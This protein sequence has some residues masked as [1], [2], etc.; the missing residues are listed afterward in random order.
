MIKAKFRDNLIGMLLLDKK[1]WMH[2]EI[3]VNISIILIQAHIDLRKMHFFKTL[4]SP[5]FEGVPK[6]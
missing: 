5:H 6:T 4:T 2:L 3:F 1:S